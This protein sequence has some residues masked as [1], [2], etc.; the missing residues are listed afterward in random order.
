MAVILHLLSEPHTF[1]ED[2]RSSFFRTVFV[3]CIVLVVRFRYILHT[4]ED[5][6]DA[7]LCIMGFRSGRQ[8]RKMVKKSDHNGC[9]R[10][11]IVI[12]AR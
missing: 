12:Q 4:C 10:N 2:V 5:S 6:S 8:G 7:D 1:T 11:R 9:V 3:F